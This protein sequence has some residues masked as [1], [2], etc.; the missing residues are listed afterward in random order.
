MSTHQP[1]LGWSRRTATSGQPSCYTGGLHKTDGRSL[2]LVRLAAAGS[3]RF[4]V[5]RRARQVWRL[6][7]HGSTPHVAARVRSWLS[8]AIGHGL[9]IGS[10]SRR[11]EVLR[12][13]GR[14][15]A[16]ALRSCLVVDAPDVSSDIVEV[17]RQDSGD[18]VGCQMAMLRDPRSARAVCVR[19]GNAYCPPLHVTTPS[20]RCSTRTPGR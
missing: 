2:M 20:H 18:L 5:S 4:L 3:S 15:I 13:L 11:E 14:P 10:P 6:G 7:R 12:E 1:S 19:L 9:G 16:A 8:E 17:L